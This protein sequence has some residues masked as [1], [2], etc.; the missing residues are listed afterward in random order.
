M[1]LNSKNKGLLLGVI[2]LLIVSYQ[3]AITKT[4]AARKAHRANYKRDIS[5]ANLPEQHSLLSKKEQ[6]LDAQLLKFNLEDTSLQ[7]NLLKFLTAQT[8]KQH[9]KIIDFNAPHSIQN[10]GQTVETYIFDLEGGYTAILKVLNALENNAGFGGI[11]H[12]AYEKKKALR[13]KRTALQARVFLE[14]MR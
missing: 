4:I 11:V 1:L 2:A 8:E 10:K 3:L 14:Q 7:N 5:A 12:V 9:V 6:Q 13:S